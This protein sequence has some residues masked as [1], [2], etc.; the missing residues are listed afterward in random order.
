[1]RFNKQK[2]AETAKRKFDDYC[3][4]TFGPDEDYD[5]PRFYYKK[6][7]LSGMPMIRLVSYL[8]SQGV[9]R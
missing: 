1:M 5:W 7:R 3:R 8:T 4:R 6:R 2:A 9:I